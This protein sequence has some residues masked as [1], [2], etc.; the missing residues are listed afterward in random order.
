[1]LPRKERISTL[2]L[3]RLLRRAA[4]PLNSAITDSVTKIEAAGNIIVVKTFPGM[5]NA[6]AVC[7][8]SIHHDDIVGSVAGDDTI[9]LVAKDTERAFELEIELKE[10]FRKK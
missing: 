4:F 1:M 2:F 8:D 7:I 5:A 6:L 9:L 3:R 10:T